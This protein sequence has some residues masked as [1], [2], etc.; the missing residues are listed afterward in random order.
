MMAQESGFSDFRAFLMQVYTDADI[1]INE[2][3]LAADDLFQ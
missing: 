2:D 1:E 3:L